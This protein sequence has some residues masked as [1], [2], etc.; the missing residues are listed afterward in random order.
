MDE[1]NQKIE[2]IEFEMDIRV[3]SLIADI[4]KYRDK[5]KHKLDIYKEKFKKYF[6]ILVFIN[7]SFS[8]FLRIQNKKHEVTASTN[9]GEK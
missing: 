8:Y 1:L 2:N 9:A 4:H 7:Y 3:E 6:V 5:Y